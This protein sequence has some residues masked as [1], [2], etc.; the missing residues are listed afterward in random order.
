MQAHFSVDVLEHYRG[1]HGVTVVRT[2][3]VGRVSR[4]GNWS[5]DFGIAPAEDMVHVSIGELIHLPAAEREHWAAHALTLPSS[6]MFL[7][8]RLSPGSCSDDGELRA[9]P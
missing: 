5:L 8:M 6:K 4:K 3:T 9:W 1:V 2:D 7:Q